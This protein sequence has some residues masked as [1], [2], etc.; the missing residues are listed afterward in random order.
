[1]DSEAKGNYLPDNG[2][3]LIMNQKVITHT[4]NQ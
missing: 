3:L 1:M 4:K 2:M